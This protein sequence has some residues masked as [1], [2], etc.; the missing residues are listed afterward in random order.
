MRLPAAVAVERLQADLSL[1]PEAESQFDSEADFDFDSV[2]AFASI[3][4]AF[5]VFD[6]CNECWWSSVARSTVAL[7][8]RHSC[9]AAL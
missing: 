1:L 8:L 6:W 2:I 3:G 7:V 9:R 5:V 4:F